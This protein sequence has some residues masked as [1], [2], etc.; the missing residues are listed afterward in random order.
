MRIYLLRHEKRDL[1]DPTFYSPLLPEGL[2]D[3]ENLKYLL[4]SFEI[5]KIYASPFKQVL[6]TVK[7]YCDMKNMKV[8]IEY[9]LYEQILNRNDSNVQ[10][11]LHIDLKSNDEE[12]YLKN[13]D[14]FPLVPLSN[15]EFTDKTHLRSTAVFKHLAAIYQKYENLNILLATH[16]GV[17]NQIANIE[18]NKWPMG[19]IALAYD[20]DEGGKIFDPINFVLD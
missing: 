17:L 6:Q 20:D 13:T 2:K 16:A 10:F 3:A 8:N 4:E 15:I 14:Y 19:G 12:F 9:G 1:H 11:N 18:D 5:N 7:P